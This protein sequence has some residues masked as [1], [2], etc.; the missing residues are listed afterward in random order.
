MA[1]IWAIAAE[2]MD[3]EAAISEAA[4]L[5]IEITINPPEL[6]FRNNWPSLMDRSLAAAAA[7]AA[8]VIQRRRHKCLQLLLLVSASFYCKKKKKCGS[9]KLSEDLGKFIF[10]KVC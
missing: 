10:E 5:T 8:V 2:T 3:I 1:E 4:I 9:K 6:V 7:A